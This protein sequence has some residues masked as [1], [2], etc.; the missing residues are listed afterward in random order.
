MAEKEIVE[1]PQEAR[2][3]IRPLYS[4]VENKGEV[5]LTI[6]MTGVKKEDLSI[7]IENSE[8]RVSGKRPEEET[9]GRY[10]VRE[11]RYGDFVNTFT[12]DDTIDQNNVDA[13]LD[14]GLLT[15][16]LHLKEEVKPKRIQIKSS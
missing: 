16:K 10:L 11:R 5:T 9:Q 4:I 15:V 6:D 2:R 8:L 14:N 1:K 3:Q 13:S 12:L 7:S